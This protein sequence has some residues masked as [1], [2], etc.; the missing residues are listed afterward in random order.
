MENATNNVLLLSSTYLFLAPAITLGVKYVL[1]NLH[2]HFPMFTILVL[3][4]MEWCLAALTQTQTTPL[5]SGNLYPASSVDS[6]SFNTPRLLAVL[7]GIFLAA[8]IGCG[9]VGL[10]T[11]DVS[12]YTM[13]KASTPAFV[14]V[15]SI[16]AGLEKASI[17][18][19]CIIGIIVLGVTLCFLGEI[20]FELSGFVFVVASCVA[21]VSGLSVI[22]MYSFVLRID[23]TLIRIP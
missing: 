5:V 6:W 15:F 19:F 2:F 11:L 7:I 12:F 10:L 17:G 16:L 18:I 1:V 23:S 9:N 4:M 20:N 13:V 22:D 21:G 8:E 14:L 3:L